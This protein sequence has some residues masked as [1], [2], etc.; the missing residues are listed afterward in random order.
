MPSATASAARA[1]AGRLPPR[2]EAAPLG[3][4][5][6]ALASV[7]AFGGDRSQF[8]RPSVHDDVSIQSLTLAANLSAEHGF[9]G[10][11][12]LRLDGDGEPRYVLYNRFPVGSYA[13]V[14]LVALPFGDDI[15]RRILAARLLMLAFFAGA[16]VLAH[17]ALARLLGDRR[18]ALGATLLAFSSYYLL[19]YSDM[20]SSEIPSLFGVMLVFHGMAVHAREGRFRQLPLRT[21]V[22]LLLGWHAA[23]LAAPFV[24]L[25]LAS[26]ARRARGG[27]LRRAAGVLARSRYLAYGAFAVLCCALVLGF[28]AANEYRALGGEV[29]P[30][31]L[32]IFD[33]IVRRSGLDAARTHVGDH[34]WAEFLRSQLGGVGGM[35]IPFA[36]ADRL[37]IDLAQ[38][39]HGLWPPPSAAP[40]LAALGA[41]AVAAAAAGLRFLPHR[42]PFAALLLAGWCWAIPFRGSAARHEFEAMFHVG[43]P[44]V[45]FALA[46]LGL[47]R[48]SGRRAALALPALALAAAAAFALSARDMAG[49]GHDAE[50]AR[51]QR[52]IVSDVEAIRG[53]AAG[54]SV[55]ARP[56]DAALDRGRVLRTFYLTGSYLQVDAIASEEDRRRL[57]A[58]DFAV[59]PADLGGSLTPDNRRIFLYALAGLDAARAAVAARG[60][61][62]SPAFEARLEGGTLRYVGDG[63]SEADAASRFFLHVLPLDAGDLPEERRRYGSE[64]FSFTFADRGA[65]YGGACFASFALPDYAVLGVRTGQYGEGGPVWADEFPLDPEAW[66]ARF[67]TLAASE[68]ALRARF[69]VH[70]EGR[71]LHYLREDCAASDAEA[72]FFLHVTPLDAGD[73]PE[74]RRAAGFAN[75]D[76]PF[77]DRGLRYEGRCLASVALPDYGVARVVTGQFDADGAIWEGEIAVR[78]R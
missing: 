7:F 4:L 70:V 9:L 8:Y 21:A 51:R 36:A 37:G 17:L 15:P 57:P 58:Y 33:S 3:L 60:P 77:A 56:I 23:A 28:N 65:R 32:P 76:F 38:S 49:V 2:N 61:A 72:R 18:I 24:L 30:H 55:V 41:A 53:L 59:L 25:G 26:E 44:L 39:H 50:A 19:H 29:P 11:T 22:A 73:L 10:F 35:A 12:R 69:G 40:R 78:D 52:E 43:V 66:L 42:L 6:L 47:R 54:R 16:A 74:E 34:G 14:K 64:R 45:L 13:L 75:L 67:E 5:L 20:V 71:T 46:L 1:L 48:L 68:P 31:D 63:C 62:A 27:G